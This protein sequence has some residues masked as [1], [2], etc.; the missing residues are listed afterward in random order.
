MSGPHACEART[1]SASS[2]VSPDEATSA[3][4]R[5]SL[6]W[7]AM[8]SYSAH[9]RVMLWLFAHSCLMV[10]VADLSAPELART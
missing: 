10:R 6:A 1:A 9:R 8:V 5:S 4:Y 7:W 3:A 2:G